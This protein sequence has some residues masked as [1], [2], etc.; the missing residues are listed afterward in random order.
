MI[1]ISMVD[2]H[3]LFLSGVKAELEAKQ[4]SR[5]SCSHRSPNLS[6]DRSTNS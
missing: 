6:I 5:Q 3:R 4:L 1:R 2:D